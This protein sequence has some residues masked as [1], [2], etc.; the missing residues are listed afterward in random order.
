MVRNKQI[1]L[2]PRNRRDKRNIYQNKLTLNTDEK[3]QRQKDFLKYLKEKNKQKE[4]PPKINPNKIRIGNFSFVKSKTREIG[5]SILA[6]RIIH[7]T[8]GLLDKFYMVS[9]EKLEEYSDP[10]GLFSIKRIR[11]QP[12][13]GVTN[14]AYVISV[15]HNGKLKKFFIKEMNNSGIKERTSGNEKTYV[16]FSDRVKRG[17]EGISEAK[18]L[19]LMK[20]IGVNI[21]NHHFA[22]IDNQRKISY[23]VYDFKSDLF[24]GFHLKKLIKRRLIP[25]S[26]ISEISRHIEEVRTKAN[27]ELKRNREFYGIEDNRIISDLLDDNIYYDIK[28][29]KVYFFDPLLEN[30]DYIRKY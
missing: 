10:K 17:L 13:V 28:K 21:I 11:L 25:F 30:L 2:K 23:I 26:K 29:D 14:V 15:K 27:E 5:Y 4:I 12:S 18:A 19:T 6:K 22:F 7:E 16:Q 1:N 9:K 8:P 3:I 24:S 20:N